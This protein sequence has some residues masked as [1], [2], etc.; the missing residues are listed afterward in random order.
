MSTFSINL[1]ISSELCKNYAWNLGVCLG[2][3]VA[4]T[5]AARVIYLIL[6]NEYFDKASS[7]AKAY[8]AMAAPA[9]MACLL[10]APRLAM[11]STLHAFTLSL[12]P[13][14]LSVACYFMQGRESADVLL[15]ASL[16]A[17]IPMERLT[18]LVSTVF[19]PACAIKKILT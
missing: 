14:A 19:G 8:T 16:Q 15:T 2:Y 3:Q 18:I 17:T 4:A 6:K 10:P 1:G 12:L 13:I 7:K 9:L 5:V 11:V